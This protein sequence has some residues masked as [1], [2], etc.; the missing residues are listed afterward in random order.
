MSL[1]PASLRPQPRAPHPSSICFRQT[2]TGER[3]T[4]S[5]ANLSSLRSHPYK[6]LGPQLLSFDTHTNARTCIGQLPSLPQLLLTLS[7]SLQSA[8]NIS[9][10]FNGFRTL[11]E[12]QPGCTPNASS[13][14]R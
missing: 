4:P 5:D 6:R 2:P 9:S 12:K 8:K 7:L 1:R 3:F 13:P 14:R 11:C 10:V